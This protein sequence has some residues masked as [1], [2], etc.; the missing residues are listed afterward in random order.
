MREENLFSGLNNAGNN[1]PSYRSKY[2]V[3]AVQRISWR[4]R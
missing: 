3:L 1:T 2:Q 4:S